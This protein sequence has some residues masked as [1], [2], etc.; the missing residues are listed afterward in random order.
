M[1]KTDQIHSLTEFQRNTKDYIERL[2]RNG[3]PAVLTVHGRP[4]LVVQ[5]AGAYQ[6]LLDSV[7]QAEAIIG[8]KR[9]L[10]S[11]RAGRGKA[12][13]AAFASIKGESDINDADE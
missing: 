10:D 12:L 5:E 1:F 4:E 13:D 11:M 2:R 6:E 9:G 3:R 7:E 8:I